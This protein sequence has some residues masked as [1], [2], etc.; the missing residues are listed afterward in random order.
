[1]RKKTASSCG[2]FLGIEKLICSKSTIV[3]DF[4]MPFYNYQQLQNCSCYRTDGYR[5]GDTI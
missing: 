2:Y 4:K 1:M 5:K 3:G